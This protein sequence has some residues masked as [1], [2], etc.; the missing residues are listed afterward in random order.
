MSVSEQSIAALLS[1]VE[2]LRNARIRELQYHSQSL[3]PLYRLRVELDAGESNPVAERLD[4]AVK[5][6]ASENM[7]RTESDALIEL[8]KHGGPVPHCYGYAAGNGQAA[9]FMRFI[10]RGRG[11]GDRLMHDLMQLYAHGN[12]RY[13]WAE[14]NFIGTLHQPNGWYEHFADFWWRARIQPQFALA[15]KKGRLSD[16]LEQRLEAVVY[17]CAARW[18]LASI[19]PRLIHGDLWSGNVLPASDGRM[20]LIDPSI[21]WGHPEQDLAMLDLFGSPL[22]LQQMER[23]SLEIGMMPGLVHRIPYWQI[24]PL[25]VHVNIFGGSY[26]TSLERAVR[27]CEEDAAQ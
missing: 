26:A 27:H 19:G 20:L 3:F 9:I 14:E 25:L 17:H 12:D 7:A 1:K 4:L 10:E 16:A 11:D 24:Y 6:V 13:G 21:A 18:N 22:S 5:L 8:Q 2:S 15:R 23:I